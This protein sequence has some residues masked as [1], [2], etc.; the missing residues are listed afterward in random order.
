MKMTAVKSGSKCLYFKKFG[1]SLL[2]HCS[3]LGCTSV[4]NLYYLQPVC[5]CGVAENYRE[6]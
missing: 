4:D 1:L 3:R 6:V 2:L 5:E